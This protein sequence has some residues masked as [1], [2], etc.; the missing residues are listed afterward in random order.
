LDKAIRIERLRAEDYVEP[1][2][3][4]FGIGKAAQH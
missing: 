4:G 1:F 3:G 2:I